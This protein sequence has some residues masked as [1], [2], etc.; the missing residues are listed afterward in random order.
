M[1]QPSFLISFR[2]QL[3][4]RSF[5]SRVPWESLKESFWKDMRFCSLDRAKLY[6]F[7]SYRFRLVEPLPSGWA[8]SSYL[9]SRAPSHIDENWAII[10]SQNLLFW[11][12]KR[13][14]YSSGKKNFYWTFCPVE[15]SSLG[16]P[17]AVN[18]GLHRYFFKIT[19]KLKM[20]NLSVWLVS[21]LAQP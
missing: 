16:F 12:E 7:V 20:V 18:R 21:L 10:I 8:S 19:R 5:S 15:V 11:G 3:K 9:M 2:S 6:L 4:M 17:A 1:V 14:S 13:G